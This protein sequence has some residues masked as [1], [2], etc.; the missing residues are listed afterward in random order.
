MELNCVRAVGE[1]LDKYPRELV[2]AQVQDHRGICVDT[3]EHSICYTNAEF[4]YLRLV[5]HS[6]KEVT[7]RMGYPFPTK[8]CTCYLTGKS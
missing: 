3:G 2:K 8:P 6:S 5:E 1:A 4:M 7:R